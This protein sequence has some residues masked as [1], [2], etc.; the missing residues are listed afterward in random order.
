M[1]NGSIMRT[2]RLRG[3]DVWE[4]R[5]RE[6]G[7]DGKR[8]HRRMV[9]GSV[10]QFVDESAVFRATCA[11]RRDIN[12]ANVRCKGK[13]IT[14][15][16][17]A[18]HYSQR[19]LAS[20]NRWKTHSTKAGYRGYLRKWIIPRW[21]RYTL[22][23]I[24]AGEI[25]LWLRSLP[26]AR[27]T[28]AKIRNVM[29]VLFNHGLRHELFDRNPVQWVRQ[30]A[31]RKKIPPVLE[32]EEV[33]SLLSAL[34]LRE[35]TMVLLDV[36][37]GLRASELFALKWTDIN[38]KK[39]EVSVTRSIVMQVVGS[40]KTEASQKPVPLDPLLART[41]RTWRLHTKY[42]AAGDWV[43]ASPYSQGRRPY[44]G[45]SLMRNRISQVAR[46]VG[47]CKKIG[48]HTFRH[49]CAT[50]LRA[51]GADIKVVQELLR[52]ASCR[53]TLDTYTQAVTE[54][55]RAAQNKIARMVRG[56]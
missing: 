13:P 7:A 26:L 35:R 4:Y 27:S 9:V 53:V 36:V 30:S 2:E 16:Q 21:G 5:W 18:D 49:T 32:I 22:N 55:K 52:H 50:L 15:S 17:L 37:T 43:F 39:N 10:N 20:G 29:S 23:S 8:R 14:L 46:A 19:E 1:Q 45:Q 47:I 44:W 34:D 56:A 42:K 25:E 40:C 28:C 12:M 11:L 38:F 54:Q 33:K 24:R 6:P 31:K 41:L 48:W 51:S 3:P